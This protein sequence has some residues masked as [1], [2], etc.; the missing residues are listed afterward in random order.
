MRDALRTRF[1]DHR[2]LGNLDDNGVIDFPRLLATL[3]R[4]TSP[5]NGLWI[6]ELEEPDRENALTRS[7]DYLASLTSPIGQDRRPTAY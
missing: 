1:R 4:S 7:R 2:A 3:S 5:Y 6:L